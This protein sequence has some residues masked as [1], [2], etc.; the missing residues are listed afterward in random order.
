MELY[1][2]LVDRLL[3]WVRS[4]R[5]TTPELEPPQVDE[6]EPELE[7]IMFDHAY[8]D[9]RRLFLYFR[10]RPDVDMTAA[11]DHTMQEFG[12]IVRNHAGFKD[13]RSEFTGRY[14]VVE[15]TDGGNVGNYALLA[16]EKKFDREINVDGWVENQDVPSGVSKAARYL[17]HANLAR[18]RPASYDV[19]PA[20][21][22]KRERRASGAVNRRREEIVEVE[23]PKPKPEPK[24]VTVEKAPAGYHAAITQEPVVASPEPSIDKLVDIIVPEWNPAKP[25]GVVL[26]RDHT[27]ALV[28]SIGET[29]YSKSDLHAII[30]GTE[31]ADAQIKKLKLEGD[32]PYLVVTLPDNMKVI[33]VV[34]T[35]NIE[36]VS[37]QTNADFDLA[38]LC[39]NRNREQ[40]VYTNLLEAIEGNERRAK[41]R[42]EEEDMSYIGDVRKSHLSSAEAPQTPEIL[43]VIYDR[44][45]GVFVIGT[46]EEHIVETLLPGFDYRF[47]YVESTLI[48]EGRDRL[49]IR[50]RVNSFSEIDESRFIGPDAQVDRSIVRVYDDLDERFG[51]NTFNDLRHV[52]PGVI[53]EIMQ[54]HSAMPPEPIE[55]LQDA[56]LVYDLRENMLYLFARG[57]RDVAMLSM[58]LH[59]VIGRT[60]IFRDAYHDMRYTRGR[61]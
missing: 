59:P 54:D 57:R 4:R 43:A 32:R 53:D 22:S 16:F 2:N 26:D 23:P 36:P 1:M 5:N 30:K 39:G 11:V 8:A 3:G 12:Y 40:R 33:D 50:A 49:S 48:F 9:Y 44:S 13:E 10:D 31:I 51:S 34:D 58:R 21:K 42:Q 45:E 15:S 18:S 35:F 28:F 27:H 25:V 47:D 55:L 38:A 19:K 46:D 14:V 61:I 41:R 6:P 37:L 56:Y 52:Q 7:A 24:K 29:P 17:F 60:P 20:R